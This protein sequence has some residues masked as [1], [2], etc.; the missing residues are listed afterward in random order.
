[1]SLARV[2]SLTYD[3]TDIQDFPRMFFMILDGYPWA[4]PEVRGGDSTVPS[5]EGQIERARKKHR[6]NIMLR[7]VLYGEGATTA[8]QESDLADA[9]LE[10][11]AL[12]D[13]VLPA[14]VL[15]CTLANGATYT[16]NARAEAVVW[17]EERPAVTM[18]EVRVRLY[19]ID[20]PYWEA[21]GS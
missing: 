17:P 18:D 12:F 11:A 3:G 2:T 10:V 14:R 7:G 8:L 9:A 19:A 20:P 21:G 16:I 4:V 6:L 15:S 5:R 13:P 1:M